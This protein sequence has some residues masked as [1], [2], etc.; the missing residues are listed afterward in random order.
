MNFDKFR[1]ITI[2]RGQAAARRAIPVPMNADDI[3]PLFD[4][5][6]HVAYMACAAQSPIPKATHA[7]GL[8]GLERKRRP[9]EAL[10]HAVLRQESEA[11]RALFAGLIGAGAEDIALVPATSYGIAT[12]AANL[13]L[14]AGQAVLVLEQQF[15]SNYYAWQAKAADAGAALK[16]VP[17]P[18]DSDWTAAVLAALTPEVAIAALPASHWTDGASLDLVAIGQACRAVGAALAI[19]ATQYIA[20]APF[21]VAAV[22]PDFLVA[23]GYKWLLCPYTTSFLYVAPWRQDGRPLEHHAGGRAGGEGSYSDR[24]A[25]GAR[26]FDVGERFNHINLPMAETSLRL[27]SGWGPAAVAAALRPL[28]DRV[29]EL[30]QERGWSVPPAGRRVAHYIGMR[31]AEPFPAALEAGLAARDIHISMRGGGIRVSPYLFGRVEEVDR[32]FAALDALA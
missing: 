28:T 12:A 10:D 26:R 19:D 20:A 14:A 31:R 24:F 25:P 11:C 18:A 8:R 3:R 4:L 16:V 1:R 5:P 7:A 21:D 32:L 2:E 23:S 30:A 15:P 22:K 13:P 6:D 17:R 27:V 9:W 29:A